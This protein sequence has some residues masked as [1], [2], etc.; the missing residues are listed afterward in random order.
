[1]NVGIS[2]VGIASLGISEPIPA[3]P[4]SFFLDGAE[5]LTVLPSYNIF[6]SPDGLFIVI[7][8]PQNPLAPA[9]A[10]DNSISGSQSIIL[11]PKPLNS[12]IRTSL[13]VL[14]TS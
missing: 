7:I 9:K 8:S 1:M 11:T 4:A 2:T 13:S 6:V 12:P 10:V 14:S 5:D 3:C